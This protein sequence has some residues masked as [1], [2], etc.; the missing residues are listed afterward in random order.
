MDMDE[1]EAGWTYSLNDSDA[2]VLEHRWN[3][4]QYG[5]GVMTIS[6][7]T[8]SFDWGK[9]IIFWV[10][11]H[12]WFRIR[13]IIAADLWDLKNGSLYSN[14][15]KINFYNQ[16]VKLTYTILL[17]FQVLAV[18]HFMFSPKSSKSYHFGAK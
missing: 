3:A 15:I 17:I 8:T 14:A 7:I 10:S 5:Y 13:A 2:H 18:L 11:S 9:L 1:M 16:S 4:A 6:Q 12:K